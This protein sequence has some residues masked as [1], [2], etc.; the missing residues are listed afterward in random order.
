MLLL[1]VGKLPGIRMRERCACSS[2]HSVRPGCRSWGHAVSSA[3][4]C[5]A[6]GEGAVILPVGHQASLKLSEL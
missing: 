2:V 6:R 3:A 1:S 5:P 4:G